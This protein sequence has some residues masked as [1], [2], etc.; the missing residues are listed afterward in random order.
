MLSAERRLML[1]SAQ[2]K[3]ALSPIVVAVDTS[4]LDREVHPENALSPMLANSRPL[5]SN[6]TATSFRLV[7]LAKA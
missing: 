2:W 4:I 6:D 1:L 5:P 7:Q 3:N